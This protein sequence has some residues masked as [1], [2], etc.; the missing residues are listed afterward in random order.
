MLV[1]NGSF[2]IASV[3][4]LITCLAFFLALALYLVTQRYSG[5]ISK[6][7]SPIGEFANLD[8]TLLHFVR[9]HAKTPTH[10]SPLIF[11]HG[12]SGN[13]KDQY[14]AFKDYLDGS[15][16]AIFIDRPGH[17]WSERANE[18]DRYPDQQARYI[19]K[20][21]DHLGYDDAIFIGHSFGCTLALSLALK[22]P[23]RTRAL[24]LLAPVAYPWPGGIALYYKI[25]AMPIIGWLFT[26]LITLPIGLGRI[27]RG[28]KC[29]FLPNKRPDDYRDKTGP[30]LVL[31][32][33]NF[34]NNAKDVASLEDYVTRTWPSYQAIK[35]PALIISGDGDNV[36]FPYIHANGLAWHLK[37]SELITLKHLGHKP[38]Y[39]VP[40]IAMAGIEKLQ[41]GN[42]IDLKELATQKD[43]LLALE[44]MSK[45]Y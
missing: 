10:R 12:A 16:D 11:I 20:L 21:L 2:L 26:H 27:D 24:L 39:M 30:E 22:A 7:H 36:V 18:D 43:K 42:T 29:V 4:I 3:L 14:F 44:V 1:L 45:G 34:R 35:A 8:G 28:T 17:G 15:T 38:D 9:I 6:T 40:E 19:I 31:R 5:K 23:D 13:L 33:D 32:P 25:A 37:N 41:T